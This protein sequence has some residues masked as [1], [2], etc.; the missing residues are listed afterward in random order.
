MPVAELYGET[1]GTDWRVLLVA[2][3]TRLPALRA[4]IVARLAALVD[5]ISHWSTSSLLSRFNNAAPGSWV[6]LP[7]DF[8]RVMRAAIDLAV[9]TDGAFD[10]A[11]GRLV[12]LW[13]FGPPGAMPMPD[14]AAISRAARVS[15]WRRLGW[16]AANARLHQPGGVALDL[17]GIAKGDAVDAIADLLAG[18][19]VDH[20][21]VEI[22]GE[23][24]G[25]GIRPDGEPWWVDLEPPPG[26]VAL[27]GLRIALHGLAV[28]TSGNYR[29]GEH[30]LDPRTGYSAQSGI[31][32]ASVI[33]DTA[34]VADG[35]ATALIVLGAEAGLALAQEH[36][37]AAR[38]VTA[39]D[40]VLTPA[41]RAMLDD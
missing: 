5:Q 27:A 32:S 24:V 30:N 23:L 21:L 34:A 17:S 16:D 33:A 1:M 9:T 26:A 7:P 36:R 11:I 8:A 31:V 19:G 6:A 2:P 38:I 3:V 37:I 13:G 12:D 20:C 14:V 35:W 4:K 10:P 41:L 22:G 25:R 40:E 29:R 18:E 15:G 39:Q 28:A